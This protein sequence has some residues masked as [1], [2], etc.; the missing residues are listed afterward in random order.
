LFTVTRIRFDDI[1]YFW[2]LDAGL[3]SVPWPG[4]YVV[5]FQLTAKALPARPPAIS[6][7]RLRLGRIV[8]HTPRVI[9]AVMGTLG[10]GE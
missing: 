7:L 8:E 10:Q 2:H 5:N 3:L 9:L 6:E 1:A 4:Y